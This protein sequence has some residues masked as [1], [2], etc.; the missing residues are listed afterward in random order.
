MATTVEVLERAPA[1]PKFV[2]LAGRL[3]QHGVE[4]LRHHGFGVR[5]DGTVGKLA[6]WV[7]RCPKCGGE[8][9]EWRTQFNR[10]KSCNS[11]KRPLNTYEHN[12]RHDRWRRVHDQLTQKNALAGQ[13]VHRR[14]FIHD[15]IELETSDLGARTIERIDSTA[16]LSIDNYKLTHEADSIAPTSLD[17][18]LQIFDGSRH[19]RLSKDSPEV[20]IRPPAAHVILGISR[21][22]V[23][24]M[25]IPLVMN[26][27]MEAVDSGLLDD[28][29]EAARSGDY[30]P[31][32]DDVDIAVAASTGD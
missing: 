2:D 7:C 22:R 14:T 18:R 1:S 3:N 32:V 16:P 6:I 25:S 19:W 10:T 13:W 31:A 4:F 15:M 9:F 12:L 24:Q 11:C 21:Q 17:E 27:L 26:R 28:L 20:I 29:F 5:R 30:Q 8:F 23:Q